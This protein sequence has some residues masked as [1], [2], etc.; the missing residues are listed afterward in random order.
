MMSDHSSESVLS[1]G[2]PSGSDSLLMA[3]AIKES[4]IRFD[5]CRQSGA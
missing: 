4:S 2:L 5:V 3:S 1:S